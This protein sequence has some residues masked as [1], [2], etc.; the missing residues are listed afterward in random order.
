M[1]RWLVMAAL[2][3]A[4]LSPLGWGQRR[5]G[6]SPGFGA[7]SSMAAP[8][9]RG[10]FT[11]S[12]GP[13]RQFV[14]VPRPR[15][16]FTVGFSHAPFFHSCFGRPCSVYPRVSSWV[17]YYPWWYGGWYYGGPSLAMDDSTSGSGAE[18]GEIM[19]QQQAEIDRLHQEVAELREAREPRASSP[20]PAAEPEAQPTEFVFR[21]G[22]SEEI[23]NYAIMDDLL[24][25]LTSEGAKKI[26]L[27]RV[28]FAATKKANDA[29]GVEF[30]TPR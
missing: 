21:D 4:F 17:G 7:H 24:W 28:D 29:R 12:A 25:V 22:H 23:R 15:A 14:P 11:R 1:A 8:G 18:M 2:G 16:R 3:A 27:S 10:G 19:E 30:K 13:R 6:F 5:A 26:P 9:M 20:A